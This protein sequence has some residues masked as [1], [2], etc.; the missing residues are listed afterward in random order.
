MTISL[1]VTLKWT[2]LVN[3]FIYKGEEDKL[4]DGPQPLS[5]QYSVDQVRVH[6]KGNAAKDNACACAVSSSALTK[7]SRP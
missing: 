2:N 1:L 5:D 3:S 4:E 7:G 6:C